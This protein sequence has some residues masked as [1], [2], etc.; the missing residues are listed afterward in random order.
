MVTTM[1]LVAIAVT[2]LAAAWQTRRAALNQARDDGERVATL[3]ARG[4]SFGRQIP[5]EV[6]QTIGEMML[7]QARLTARF[8]AAAEAAGMSTKTINRSLYEAVDRSRSL[9]LWVT[10]ERGRAYLHSVPGV[11][12]SFNPDPEQQPQAA[13]FWKLLTGEAQAIVEPPKVREI[14]DKSFKYVGVAGVDKRRIVQVGLEV[15]FLDAIGKRTGILALIQAMVG[16]GDIDAIWVLSNDL[17]TIAQA[18]VLGTETSSRPSPKELELV[19][20]VLASDKPVSLLDGGV[21]RVLA[22]MR[23]QGKPI[24]AAIV[25]LSTK[26]LDA[27]LAAQARWSIGLGVSVLLLGFVASMV[28]AKRVTE[29]VLSIAAAAR[30]M[31]LGQGRP[32]SVAGLASRR[33]ELGDLART[34]RAMST[35]IL[36]REEKLDGL[37]RERTRELDH[38]HSQLVAANAR[39]QQELAAARAFQVAILPRDLV[40]TPAYQVFGM[41]VPAREVGGDFY[42]HFPLPDG[43]LA[44]VIGDVSGK[45]VLAAL[46]M[47]LARTAIRSAM[48]EGGSPG[49]TL[50]DVNARLLMD[51]PLDLFVSVFCAIFDPLS[52]RLVYA[53]GGHPPPLL[54]G[55]DGVP[56]RLASTGGVLLGILADQSFAENEVTIE[57]NAVLFLYSDGFTEARGYDGRMFGEAGVSH[58][59]VGCRRKSAEDVAV[60]MLST[61]DAFAKDTEQADDITCLA[62]LRQE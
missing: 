58:G 14:D 41:M 56:E 11:E 40:R 1:L 38:K 17:Q 60:R 62:L 33:D 39:I 43:R 8:A 32:D 29:P 54:L 51:N 50:A 15:G 9:E 13:V 5:N 52:G 48:M 7:V 31:E 55:E 34:F 49:G 25:R 46:F 6:E 24:G 20:T 47:V 59:L 3:L 22:P 53:N 10:D 4:A 26:S 36:A 30:A 35:A 44:V 27:T 45:G 61:V 2:S 18:S 12:F 19:G 21:L 23:E 57:P 28:A 16:E 37:V 42:D